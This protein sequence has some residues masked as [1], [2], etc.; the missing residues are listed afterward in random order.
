MKKLAVKEKNSVPIEQ[1]LSMQ[2]TD[3]KTSQSSLSDQ[4]NPINTSLNAESGINLQHPAALINNANEELKQKS[5]TASFDRENLEILK[6]AKKLNNLI[7]SEA[8]IDIESIRNVELIS[9]AEKEK[10]SET[11]PFYTEIMDKYLCFSPKFTKIYPLQEL[12]PSRDVK[13]Y[14]VIFQHRKPLILKIT[15]VDK[16]DL[17][18]IDSLYR[19]YFIAHTISLLTP[20]VVKVLDIRQKLSDQDSRLCIELLME[21]AGESLAN[22]LN[23]DK[24]T[25][26]KEHHLNYTDVLRVMYQLAQVL[27]LME[28]RGISHFDIKPEN[29]AIDIKTKTMKLL[30]FGSAFVFYHSPNLIM[31][32]LCENADKLTAITYLYAPP[33]AINKGK[34]YIHNLV[35]QKYDAFAF[36]LIFLLLLL[37]SDSAYFIMEQR[38]QMK[39][40]ISIEKHKEWL[41]MVRIQL[42]NDSQK[43]E[44]FYLLKKCL[45]FEFSARP[46]FKTIRKKMYNKLLALGFEYIADECHAKCK[47]NFQEL[48]KIAEN[49]GEYHNVVYCLKKYIKIIPQESYI[50][51][52]QSKVRLAFAYLQLGE[53]RK[54]IKLLTQP[55]IR[56]LAENSN[57]K[58]TVQAYIGNAYYNLA[59]ITKAKRY[60]EKAKNMVESDKKNL[61]SHSEVY[62]N[63]GLIFKSISYLKKAKRIWKEESERSYS[64]LVNIFI[65]IGILYKEEWELKDA[66]QYIKCAHKIANFVFNVNHPAQAITYTYLSNLYNIDKRYITASEYSYKSDE[67]IQIVYGEDHPLLTFALKNKGKAMHGRGDY[68]N[69]V[70]YYKKALSN[71]NRMYSK[72]VPIIAEIY[73]EL[74]TAYTYMDQYNDAHCYLDKAIK[75][76][77]VL[78]GAQHALLVESYN[79]KG[80]A[81]RYA[82]NYK[83][84]ITCYKKAD[85]II[86]KDPSKVDKQSQALTYNNLG[87]CCYEKKN[88]DEAIK[89]HMSALNLRLELYGPDH[90]YVAVSY[91]NLGFS[92][93][94]KNDYQ[95]ALEYITKAQ[96]I[97]LQIYKSDLH[98]NVGK[99][100]WG[101]GIIYRFFNE[102]LK[103]DEYHARAVEIIKKSSGNFHTVVAEAYYFWGMSKLYFTKY[104][105]A[106]NF[107][108]KALNIIRMKFDDDYIE[109]AK[110]YWDLSIAYEKTKKYQTAYFYAKKAFMGFIKEYGEYDEKTI[111]A[112][113]MINKYAK[114]DTYETK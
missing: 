33:E 85:R 61:I 48:A 84:A 91:N 26:T 40:Y 79:K 4:E 74:G 44:W 86:N 106:I 103:S 6:F 46:T 58:A 71:F 83:D 88:Y 54:V 45:S 99:T 68:E 11:R 105:E 1:K 89:Y 53:Y 98:Q 69:A 81:Y 16:N 8:F 13:V 94:G 12:K 34:K 15:K 95:T 78:Y 31:K 111:E 10:S 67:I 37:N 38:H 50:L 100:F 96:N 108:Q 21:D 73:E 90:I 63:Y 43:F 110:I 27:E 62:S 104:D 113:K 39:K 66:F 72:Y 2:G 102:E 23:Y 36:G 64:V 87:H 25:N 41:D 77:K 57:L 65:N 97:F 51:K 35:P 42:I 56:K 55:F 59:K 14:R 112:N 92:Y 47:L 24:S 5:K 18:V 70:K 7:K 52:F 80:N 60:A 109:V 19:E 9:K 32:N 107:L 93:L 114:Y 101:L 49:C 76:K 3:Y 28:E 29:I 20:Y 17:K 30:D 82:G 22:C 75:I